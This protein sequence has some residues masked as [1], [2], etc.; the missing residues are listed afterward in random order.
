MLSRG[1]VY[2]GYALIMKLSLLIIALAVYSIYII[3]DLMLYHGLIIFEGLKE[4]TTSV[5][6]ADRDIRTSRTAYEG[7]FTKK[8]SEL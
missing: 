2:I 6:S 3:M 5:R 1:N 4:L 7:S 8:Y